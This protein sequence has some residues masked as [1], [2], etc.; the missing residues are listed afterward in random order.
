MILALSKKL[1]NVQASA[2]ELSPG[3]T[4]AMYQ[5]ALYNA[6]LNRPEKAIPLLKRVIKEDIVYCLKI[7]GEQDFKRI[8]SEIA[9]LLL[10]DR[11]RGKRQS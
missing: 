11:K 9:E 4:E 2:I 6:L 10:G 1:E 8:S 7:C 5:N 3:F